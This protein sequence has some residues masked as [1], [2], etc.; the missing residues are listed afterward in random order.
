MIFSPNVI[1]EYIDIYRWFHAKPFF[2]MSIRFKTIE[3]LLKYKQDFEMQYTITLLLFS[4][5]VQMSSDAKVS[6]VI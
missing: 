3:N 2:R 6:K 4:Q 1:P 5:C